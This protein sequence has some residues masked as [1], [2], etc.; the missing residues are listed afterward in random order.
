MSGRER[1]LD[2]TASMYLKIAARFSQVKAREKGKKTVP[3]KWNS[4]SEVNMAKRQ[5]YWNV[6]D[7]KYRLLCM[8]R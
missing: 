2:G 8:R 3:G 6:G 7:R 1:F 4:M 5:H